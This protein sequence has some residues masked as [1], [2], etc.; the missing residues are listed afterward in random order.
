MITDPRN[1]LGTL[2]PEW[3]ARCA[4]AHAVFACLRFVPGQDAPF[5]VTALRPLEII[6]CEALPAADALL[7]RDGM[8]LAVKLP[9]CGALAHTAPFPE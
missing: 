3:E 1:Q 2:P 7:A 4:G 9:A 5:V 6:A 8:R